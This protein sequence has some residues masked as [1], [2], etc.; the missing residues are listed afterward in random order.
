MNMS[1]KVSVIIP[2]YN[3][4]AYIEQCVRAL[5]EQSLEEIE[6]IFIDDCG[7]DS[8]MEII[9]NQLKKYP[10]RE[11]QVKIIRH[12]YNMGVS[13]SR[14]DGV[15]AAMGEYIIHCDPDDR[16]KK[17]MYKILYEKAVENRADMAFC[18]FWEVSGS[19]EKY[20][21]QS[22]RSL[23]GTAILEDIVGVRNNKLHGALWNKLIKSTYSKQ[24]YFPK[25]IN[26][27]EDVF[28]L[29]QILPLIGNKV[30]YLPEA[31][32]YY[33]KDNKNSI[34]SSYNKTQMEEDRR[35]INTVDQLI[36]DGKIEEQLAKVFISSVI[37]RD[38]QT[39][40]YSD[41]E[42]KKLYKKHKDYIKLNP[43]LHPL[44]KFFIN[45]SFWGSH[46]TALFSW[47]TILRIYLALKALVKK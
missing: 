1:T 41:K 24:A 36:V 9:A 31:L 43:N 13:Q 46:K 29:M 27:C 34:T 3:A 7:Q 35:L 26:Y 8:S 18:D 10:H 25:D 47:R 4:E 12:P 6:Y 16:P 22:P 23:D 21:K 40:E 5:F 30:Y 28:T 38:F 2:V 17:D 14:Q 32:Y 37:A 15:S 42:F 45:M 44:E 11:S 39:E 20:V 33:R 19:K